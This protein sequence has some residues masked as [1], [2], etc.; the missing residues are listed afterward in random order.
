PRTLRASAIIVFLT[1]RSGRPAIGAL[2]E[3]RLNRVPNLWCDFD[4]VEPGD[5]LDTGW[6]GDID[7]GEPAADYIDPDKDE[8]LGAQ[9]RPDRGADLVVARRQ[10]GL[11]RARADMEVGA[12]VAF[13]RHPQDG[14]HSLA[15]DQNDALVALPHLR[16]IALHHDRLTLELL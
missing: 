14:A 10:L 6:R 3:P 9:S 11:D 8:P 4:A 15:L 2:R 1:L 7:L 13:W 12:G 5:L 16:H